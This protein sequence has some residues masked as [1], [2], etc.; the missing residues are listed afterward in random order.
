MPE[1]TF[2]PFS[3]DQ[4]TPEQLEAMRHM[5]EQMT[6]AVQV[7]IEAFEA[8][9]RACIAANEAVDAMKAAVEDSEHFG[10]GTPDLIEFGNFPS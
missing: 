5:A 7:M 10:P 1:P 8:F 2:P 3:A 4:L 6:T 9:S